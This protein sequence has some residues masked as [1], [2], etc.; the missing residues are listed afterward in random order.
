MKKFSKNLFF[1]F[2]F[3]LFSGYSSYIIS[4]YENNSYLK[5]ENENVFNRKNNHESFKL[6]KIINPKILEKNKRI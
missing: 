2:I 4:I 1:N 6:L 5:I 3:N